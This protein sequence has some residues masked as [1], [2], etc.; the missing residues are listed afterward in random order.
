MSNQMFV[1]EGNQQIGPL[2]LDQIQEMIRAGRLQTGSYCWMEG[3]ANWQSLGDTR[4]ELF[5]PPTPAAAPTPAPTPAPIP[6]APA[7][8]PGAPVA[9]PMPSGPSSTR[10]EI[11]DTEF[12]HMPRITLENASV[13]VEA[14]AMHYM[15]GNI[16]IQADLPSVGG[17]IKSKLTK[18]KVVRPVYSGTGDVFLEPTFG[19]CNILDLNNEEW[20]LDRGSFLACDAGV[21]IGMLT[22]KAWSGFFS[23]EGFFQTSV[24][25]RGK[26]LFLS[27]GPLETVE[28]HGETLTVDGSF[29]VAR[30]AGL[31]FKVERATKKLFSSWASG[32]GLVNTFRGSGKV[33]IAPVS[34]RFLTL[35]S[36]FKGLHYAISKI[37]RS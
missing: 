18:E 26:V 2:S 7:P 1:M 20:I 6:A 32:E 11:L 19:E 21:T 34:N 35:L 30:T 27:P 23:G 12:Y 14:G 25:G 13:T 33:L 24:S 10:F 4:P 28:L 8:A 17:M 9:Q 5:L 31:E 16:Q 36:E 15:L 37:S 29:A 3:M 22:N